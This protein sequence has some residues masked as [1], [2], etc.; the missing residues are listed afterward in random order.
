MEVNVC[1][2]REGGAKLVFRLRTE[3]WATLLL[4]VL[5]AVADS[6][7]NIS[8]IK[9]AGEYLF[10]FSAM[11]L[12]TFFVCC[13]II[14]GAKKLIFKAPLVNV[15][16]KERLLYL[17]R[18]YFTLFIGFYAYSHLKVLIPLVNQA[19][20]DAFFTS[21]DKFLFFG[22]SPTL[23]MIQI[24][25]IFF[26]KLMYLSY[27]S[28]YVGF[29]LAIAIAFVFKNNI[30]MRRLVL[31]I[32]AIYFMGI[33]LYYAFPSV[34]PL[35]LSPEMFSHIPNVWQKILWDGHLAVANG[36][37]SFEPTPFLGVAAFPS[38]HAAHFLFLFLVLAKEY[39]W[40]TWFFVPWTILLYMAT[41]YMGWH[42]VSDLVAGAMMA[43]VALILC[44]RSVK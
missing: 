7:F 3:E 20:Y 16:T 8:F 12:P 28:F 29:P 5:A 36:L 14:M 10:F 1:H 34:G 2:P 43:I 22:S 39:K 13:F 26:V 44:N 9:N 17:A 18:A 4:F 31:G 35:F 33:A 11:L 24:K 37:A 32:L 27:T 15:M 19:N 40:V 25:N 23:V 41:I 30:L 38:L 42:Y 6:Y 21:L